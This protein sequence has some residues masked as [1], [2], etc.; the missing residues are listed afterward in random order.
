ML[1]TIKEMELLCIFHDG[2][3]ASTLDLLRHTEEEG[4]CPPSR[5]GDLNRLIEKLD[6]MKEGESICLE[7]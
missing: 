6:G 1:L 3:L 7:M 2:S 4:T 5:A